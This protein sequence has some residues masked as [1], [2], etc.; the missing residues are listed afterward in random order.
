MS[1]KTLL[2]TGET[3]IRMDKNRVRA[4][5]DEYIELCKKH[6]L[7]IDHITNNEKY[8]TSIHSADFVDGMLVNPPG[9]FD[10]EEWKKQP[11]WVRF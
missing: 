5:W 1:I 4:F 6:G 11:S 2:S 3:H 8:V 9:V 7:K 10:D